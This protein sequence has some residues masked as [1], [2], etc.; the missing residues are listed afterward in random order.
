MCGVPYHAARRYIARL[1]EARAKVAICEQVE[2][3]GQRPRAS[4]GARSSRIVTP[5]TVLDEDVLEPPA[6][7]GLAAVRCGRRRFT[8]PR[9][10]DVSTGEFRALQGAALRRCSR[11]VA[12]YE[13]RELLVPA[14]RVRGR[15]DGRCATPGRASRSP[16]ASPRTSTPRG[17][18]AFLRAHFGVASLEAFGIDGR[19]P[20]HRRRRRGAALPQGH[21][22]H[23]ARATSTGSAGSAAESTCVLDETTRANLEV[24]RTLRDGSR[25]GS[26]LGVMDRTVTAL[27]ARAARRVAARAAARPRR[28]PRP[29]GRRG[30][31]VARKAVWREA[32]GQRCSRQVADLERLAR[33]ARARR[34][35]RRGTCAASAGA[36]RRCPGSRPRSSGCRA[37]LLA[38]LRRAA[39]ALRALARACSSARWWTSRRRR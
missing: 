7:P 21:P 19:P 29:A 32:L 11:R 37:A 23:R 38:A 3:A 39:P 4:S 24:L 14:G 18:G 6:P 36:W 27:G 12:A 34:S 30:G 22:E 20:G 9:C 33:T 17:P 8:A 13:P 5:G 1:I 31:A 15:A 10:L 35:A 25:A 16:S 26:L 28:H 2:D